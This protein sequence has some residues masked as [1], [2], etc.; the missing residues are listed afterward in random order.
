M[1][2]PDLNGAVTKPWSRWF[3][4]VSGFGL[5]MLASLGLGLSM[6]TQGGSVPVVYSNS[7]PKAL[8]IDREWPSHLAT[9]TFASG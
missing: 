1:N 6:L 7:H 2:S 4:R 3:K 9:F 8:D 5:G